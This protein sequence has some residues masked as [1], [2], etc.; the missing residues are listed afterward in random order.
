LFHV[1]LPSATTY[2]KTKCLIKTKLQAREH[3]ICFRGLCI[4]HLLPFSCPSLFMSSTYNPEN[5]LNVYACD[6]TSRKRLHIFM[7][8]FPISYTLNLLVNAV[9]LLNQY[10]AYFDSSYAALQN[11]QRATSFSR[12]QIDLSGCAYVTA[13]GTQVCF[14]VGSSS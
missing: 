14:A 5:F 12:Y 2:R 7:F 11:M 3:Y 8:L 1:A 13:A 6:K 9:S 10:E 4:S